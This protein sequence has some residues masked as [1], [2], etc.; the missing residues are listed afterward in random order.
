MSAKSSV[1]PA[2]PGRGL[3]HQVGGRW[4]ASPWWP[5]APLAALL[6]AGTVLIWTRLHGLDVSL[7]HDEVISVIDYS[8]RG[9]QAIL[10]GR[11][12]PNN[13][14][15]FNLLAWASS[16]LFGGDEVIPRLWSVLPALAAV[17]VVVWWCARRGWIWVGVTFAVLAAASPVHLQYAKEARGYGLAMLAAAVLLVS[18]DRITRYGPNRWL[19]VFGTAGVVGMCTFP[20]FVLAFGG[21][22]AALL[23]SRIRRRQVITSTLVAAFGTLVFY[24]PVIDQI[25]RDTVY[26]FGALGPEAIAAAPAGTTPPNP[27]DRPPVPLHTAV[28]GPFG[29]LAAPTFE[30]ILTGAE[31]LSCNAACYGGLGLIVFGGLPALLAAAGAVTLWR[32]DERVALLQLALPLFLPFA[33]LS[34]ARF[35]FADRYMSFLLPY[36]L[37]LVALGVVAIFSRLLRTRTLGL[38]AAALGL[39]IGLLALE[40]TV[41]LE[42]AWSKAPRENFKQAAAVVRERGAGPVFSNSIRPQGLM[43]YLDQEPI[44]LLPPE[45]VRAVT[46]RRPGPFVFIDHSL[47]QEPAD[48]SCLRRRAARRF[49]VSQ[50]ERGNI[51]VWIVSPEGRLRPS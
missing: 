3:T 20:P 7:W 42:T 5:R 1:S 17:G 18:A 22:A 32:K 50:R 33:A 36:V 38:A 2:S 34:L 28:S 47:F 35:F 30:L 44:R 8:S 12:E 43:R 45:Q 39:A 49:R 48:L 40:R 26:Y 4:A 31:R 37:V 23:L 16:S 13:H 10:F 29:V 15:L 51:D 19:A 24:A 6:L 11:Y 14:A 41:V 46:C 25:A 27:T 9:P 21:Q